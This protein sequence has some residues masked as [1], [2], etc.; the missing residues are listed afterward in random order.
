MII[1]LICEDDY[2]NASLSI[3]KTNLKN[4]LRIKT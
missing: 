3:T 4:F 1:N 2:K